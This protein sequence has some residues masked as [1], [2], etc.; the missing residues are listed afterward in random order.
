MLFAVYAA[1]L[2]VGPRRAGDEGHRLVGAAAVT[3][4]E[5]TD[6]AGAYR[7]RVWQDWGG[8]PVRPVGEVVSGRRVEPYGI[9]MSLLVAPAYAI[10]GAVAVELFMAALA[11]LAFVLAAALARRVVPD[12]WA[13]WAAVLAALSPPALAQATA[14][15][16]LLP[17][18]ALLCAAAL[19][20]LRARERPLMRNAFGGGL[21]LALLPWLDPWLLIPAAPVAFLLARWTARRGR[22]VV[23]LGSLEI[24]LAS[25]VFYA[26]LNERLYGGLTPLA[27]ADAPATG[28][29][30]LSDYAER[31]PRLV[32]A[33]LERD[34]GLLRWAPVVALVLLGAWLLLRSRRVRLA[35][36]VAEQRDAEHAAFLALAVCGA[37]L[38]AAAFTTPSLAGL[39]AALV[40]ALPCA[41]APMAWGLRHAP[42]AGW[43]LGAL[44]LA[45]SLWLVVEGA[46]SA[47][48]DA[49]WGPIV[50]VFP[51]DGSAGMT[52]V[53]VGAVVVVAA[54]VVVDLRRSR[55]AYEL[56][57]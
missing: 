56:R 22:S 44:T 23:A 27:V 51:V 1:T 37:Q 7:A 20:A 45:G 3:R 48:S 33:G 16:P 53:A 6:L 26:S 13:T 4:G 35:R 29:S 15:A 57:H 18:G 36:L 42:V 17:A 21:A 46:W 43:A 9:G 14:V 31:L 52:V 50:R 10:G 32:G 8:P 49:P 12:P 28:A 25:L 55:G 40:P 2:G 47:S 39:G 30:S 38:I 11:A 54:A 19:C 34:A 5:W 41:V 24:Q